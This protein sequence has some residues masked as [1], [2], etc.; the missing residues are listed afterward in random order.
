MVMITNKIKKLPELKQIIANLKSEGKKI[1][2][3]NGCF[4]LIHL[5]HIELL[6]QAKSKGDLLVVAINS[7]ASVK[8]IKE[9]GRPVNKEEARARIIAALESVDF[10]TIFDEDNPLNV[11]TALEP[12]I[13]VKGGDWKDEDI[14]GKDFVLAYNGKVLTLPYRKSYS[15]TAIIKRIKDRF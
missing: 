11:I 14:V 10:V 13:L 6:I 2:F 8:I 4:D 5:G 12:D 7:D 3:T 1:V 9:K 15:T